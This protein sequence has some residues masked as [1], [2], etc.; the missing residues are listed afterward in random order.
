[1]T[2]SPE[3]D[4]RIKR[5][6]SGGTGNLVHVSFGSGTGELLGLGDVDGVGESTTALGG[7]GDAEELAW[8]PQLATARANKT[9]SAR[10]LIATERTGSRSKPV[11]VRRPVPAH[12]PLKSQASPCNKPSERYHQNHHRER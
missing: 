4:P 9:I 11:S 10:P 5:R 12:R 7:A 6:G 8:G 1:M 2:Y 3:M